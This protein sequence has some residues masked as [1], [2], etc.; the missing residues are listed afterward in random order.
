MTNIECISSTGKPKVYWESEGLAIE[1][2]KYLNIKYPK[3]D[4][5]LS[6]YNCEY[7]HLTTIDK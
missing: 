3:K 6:H 5:Q 7:F 2:A 1:N 4:S